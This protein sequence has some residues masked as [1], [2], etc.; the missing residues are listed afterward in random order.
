M[1]ESIQEAMEDIIPKKNRNK[2][3]SW[4]TKEILDLMEVRRKTKHDKVEYKKLNKE[5]KKKC[6]E[7]KE[8]WI[9][10]QCKEIEQNQEK[11]SKFMHSKIN[12]V[13]GRKRY[14]SSPGCIQA[15]DGTMLMEKEEVL[16]RLSDMLKS[17]LEMTDDQKPVIKRNLE[18][19]S[20]LQEEVKV[21]IKKMKNGK[22]IGPDNIPVEM[23][24]ALDDL[25]ID[26]TTKLLNAIYDS[27]TIPEDLCKSVFI[28]L[29][30]G[31]GVTECELHRTIS[32]MSHFTKILLRVLMQRMRKSIKPE[33]SMKQFGFVF[34]A[35]GQEMLYL[36]YKCSW[37]D[38]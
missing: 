25:G 29:P 4:M 26:M 11:D 27:G 16:V 9:N 36:P 35:K 13:T 17:F 12:E 14:C 33:I 10:E 31:P 30:K 24:V 5:I 1:K 7:E 8:K 34:G 18:G 22:A 20:I 38:L 21:A 37:R 6:N 2:G 28:A 3:K 23:I 15:L 32:L 19:P